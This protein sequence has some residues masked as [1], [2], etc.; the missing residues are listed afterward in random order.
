MAKPVSNLRHNFHRLQDGRRLHYLANVQE[1]DRPPKHN[2]VIFIHGFPDSCQLWREVANSLLLQE[3][4]TI[5]AVDL[6][7]T[8]GSESYPNY[9]ATIVLEALTE[10]VVAMRE[11]Y[12]GEDASHGL[13][14]TRVFIIGHDWGG[15]LGF[16]LATEAVSGL[17]DR[18][19]LINGPHVS[20]VLPF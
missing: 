1:A 19:I 3:K 14:A 4:S 17:A 8:G 10:F 12:L 11:K 18:Y 20:S 2:L 15:L 9:G 5:V 6:P 13:S 7:G 16:R